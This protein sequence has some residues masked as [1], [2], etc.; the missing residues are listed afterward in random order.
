MKFLSHRK[1]SDPENLRQQMV[2]L[3]I[4][5]TALLLFSAY[6]LNN[7]KT[8]WTN[9]TESD[10]GLTFDAV[11][12]PGGGLDQVTK[13]PHAWVISRLD[14]ALKY[15]N[16]T[17]YFIVL[18]R[19][20]THKPPPLDSDGFPITEAAASARYLRDNGVIDPDRILLDT[21]SLDTI[22]NAFFA[23][24]MICQPLNLK[25]LCVITNEFHMPRTRV[26]FDWIFSQL[27][28][29]G[30]AMTY[31]TTPDVG[32][33]HEQFTLRSQKEQSSLRALTA[34]TIPKHNTFG[35]LTSF[36][37]MHHGAYNARSLVSYNVSSGSFASDEDWEYNGVL[38]TY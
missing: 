23:R 6:V 27:D 9:Q 20:S 19:G 21:W 30:V 8:T 22:G 37:L 18:S 28:P 33:P 31:H 29:W 24:R 13:E 7:Q 5:R 14:A 12:V 15:S 11:I 2:V 17:K 16:R 1:R 3:L 10:H 34:S 4:L 38:S 32:L 25:K 36:L 35:K 26:I